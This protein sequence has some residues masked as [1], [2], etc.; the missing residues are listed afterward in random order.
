[1]YFIVNS[2]KKCCNFYFSSAGE[3]ITAKFELASLLSS[4][5]FLL[6]ALLFAAASL[7]SALQLP[8]FAAGS[9]HNTDL[10]LRTS[11]WELLDLELAEVRQDQ[12][13]H[14]HQ[15]Q[16]HHHQVRLQDHHHQ[17]RAGTKQPAHNRLVSFLSKYYNSVQV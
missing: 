13:N 17:V 10:M 15:V 6:A 4:Q 11:S 1:M 5:Q 14:H 7:A 12:D 9:V 16:D 2:L 3:R 8:T